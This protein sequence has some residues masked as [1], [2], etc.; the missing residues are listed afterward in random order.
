MPR[1]FRGIV[2]LG[3]EWNGENQTLLTTE[4]TFPEIQSVIASGNLIFS[5]SRFRKKQ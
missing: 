3:W 1:I 5:Y 4:E 2:V